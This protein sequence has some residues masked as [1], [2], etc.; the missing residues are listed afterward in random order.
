MESGLTKYDG[1]DFTTFSGGKYLQMVGWTGEQCI[2]IICSV[3]ATKLEFGMM[4]R[5]G[6]RH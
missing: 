2:L 4:E 5:I 6:V 3:M 1:M